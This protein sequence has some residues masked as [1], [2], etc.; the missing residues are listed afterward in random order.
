MNLSNNKNQLCLGSV[1]SYK[2]QKYKNQ[3][4]NFFATAIKLNRKP[5]SNEIDKSNVGSINNSSDFRNKS[6][7]LFKTK[8]LYLLK[9]NNINNNHLNRSMYINKKVI[10]DQKTNLFMSGNN[11]NNYSDIRKTLFRKVYG[12]TLLRR[13]NSAIIYNKDIVNNKM[14]FEISSNLKGI[15]DNKGNN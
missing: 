5:I 10:N 3:R 12:G 7:L 11:D 4:N 14:K 1:R 6:A 8:G 2:K 9:N 15:I 13:N